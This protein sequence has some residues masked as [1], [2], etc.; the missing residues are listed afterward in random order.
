M[1][2]NDSCALATAVNFYK[3]CGPTL[4]KFSLT[5]AQAVFLFCGFL[6]KSSP[7]ASVLGPNPDFENKRSSSIICLNPFYL[8]SGW[9]I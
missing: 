4:K 5:E 3:T 1:V 8:L 2:G 6:N 9:P 7:A